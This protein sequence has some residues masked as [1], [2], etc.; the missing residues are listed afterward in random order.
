MILHYQTYCENETEHG[1]SYMFYD[2]YKPFYRKG[3]D[4]LLGYYVDDELYGVA[5]LDKEKYA[6]LDIR[7]RFTLEG[8]IVSINRTVGEHESYKL[9]D[10]DIVFTIDRQE[11]MEELE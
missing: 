10:D 8:F 6:G 2:H 1:R 4:M 11:K 7:D 5:S 9:I 3:A